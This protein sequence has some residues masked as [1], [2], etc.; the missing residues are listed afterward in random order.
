V[1]GLVPGVAA[2][3]GADGF[4]AGGLGAASFGKYNAPFCPQAERSK[5]QAKTRVIGRTRRAP[6]KC[7]KYN[8]FDHEI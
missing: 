5:P 4:T 6:E 7:S 8:V 1:A 3:A 2:G